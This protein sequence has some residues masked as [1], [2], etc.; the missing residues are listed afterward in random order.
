MGALTNDPRMLD[1]HSPPPPCA[2]YSTF[3]RSQLS[4][5]SSYH[6]IQRPNSRTKSR[7]RLF[8]SLLFKATSTASLEISISSNSR[9]LLP[10]LQFSYCNVK[11]TG[12]KPNR[13]PYPLP[14]GL[15]NPNRY[16]KSENSQDYA[17]KPQPNCTFMNSPF[18]LQNLFTGQE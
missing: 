10:F 4:S 6:S 12:G 13:N 9:N 8:C 18:V 11:E 2:G 14:Y 15:R 5:F 1:W 3:P 17:K 16:R 7:Q